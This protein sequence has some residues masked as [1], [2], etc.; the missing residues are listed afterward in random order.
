VRAKISPTS[1]RGTIAMPMSA[2]SPLNH[3]GPYPAT[4]LV[5]TATTISA[6]PTASTRGSPSVPSSIAAPTL[7]K[8]IGTKK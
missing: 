5:T 8:N 2:L 4:N 3:H 6:P 7:A 1:P